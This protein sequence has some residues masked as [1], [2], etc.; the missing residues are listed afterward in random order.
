[1][2]N[3][4]HL[5]TANHPPIQQTRRAG[6]H[7]KSIASFHEAQYQRR[8]KRRAEQQCYEEEQQQKDLMYKLAYAVLNMKEWIGDAEEALRELYA[9]RDNA[10]ARN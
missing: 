9:Q 6:R 10:V 8:M 2:S 3:V 4:H 1:M 7:P 5:P